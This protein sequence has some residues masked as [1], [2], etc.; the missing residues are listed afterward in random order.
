[1]ITMTATDARESLFDLIKQANQ[2]HEMI[3]V[4]HE[5]GNMVMMSVEDY[6]NLQ[7]TSHSFSVPNIQQVIKR[8]RNE[9]DDNL[10]VA[11]FEPL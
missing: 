11:F 10:G 7:G 9:A 5:T 4:Q 1:M 8:P 6:E 3:E 2:H